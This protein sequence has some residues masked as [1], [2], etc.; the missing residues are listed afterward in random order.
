MSGSL[1]QGRLTGSGGRGTA[2]DT[3]LLDWRNAWRCRIPFWSE[4]ADGSVGERQIRIRLALAD[5]RANSDI[6]SSLNAVC[7]FHDDFFSDSMRNW[8]LTLVADHRVRSTRPEFSVD[9][10]RK[11]I[12]GL[13]ENEDYFP[14]STTECFLWAVWAMGAFTEEREADWSEE[15]FFPLCLLNKIKLSLGTEQRALGPVQ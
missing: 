13:I 15:G 7:L 12:R 9:L 14:N 10:F 11:G 2:R 5:N 4:L 3:H 6:L 1:F 8:P